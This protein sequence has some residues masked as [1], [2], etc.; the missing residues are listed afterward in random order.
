MTLWVAGK[1]ET[2]GHVDGRPELLGEFAV[3]A[4]TGDQ[5]LRGALA[6][7]HEPL[8]HVPFS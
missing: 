6:Q 2:L 4:R 8:L 1:R 7:R 5:H 3:L